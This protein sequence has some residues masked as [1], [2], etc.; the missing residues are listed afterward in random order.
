MTTINFT[1]ADP[2][3][4]RADL[5]LLSN[6]YMDWVLGEL[7]AITGASPEAM[8]GMPVATYVENSLDKV[9]SELPP[10]GSFYLVH[11]DGVLA[12]MGGLRR[13]EDGVGEVKR[14]YVRP[15]QRGKGLG[16][17]IMQRVLADAADFGYARMLL[18]SA[19][20][21]QSAHRLYE[22]L[23]FQYRSAYEPT[24]VP[25]QFHA[26]WRFMERGQ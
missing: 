3:T 7:S 2:H 17:A 26:I 21:M 16:E 12:G 8:M 10:V 25:T 20:F 5:L 13:V 22:N 4:H 1:L 14:I 15:S 6:E 23:G 11:A 9:C 18:D 24:E 19:P